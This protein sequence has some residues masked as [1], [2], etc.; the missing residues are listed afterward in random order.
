[1]VPLSQDVVLCILCIT[2]SCMQTTTEIC[3]RIIQRRAKIEY[4]DRQ[5]E[6]SKFKTLI[7]QRSTFNTLIFKTQ[8]N[9]QP[10]TDSS[11]I[12]DMTDEL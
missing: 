5:S 1:M 2:W 9:S 11:Q 3:L 6:W 4:W 8:Q 12:I 10:Y 7:F